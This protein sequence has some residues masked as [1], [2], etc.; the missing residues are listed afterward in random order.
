MVV[1]NDGAEWQRRLG[2]V[3]GMILASL[4]IYLFFQS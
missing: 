3:C 1:I 4:G 2:L